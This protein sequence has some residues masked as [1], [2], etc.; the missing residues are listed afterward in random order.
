[1]TLD[2][3]RALIARWCNS[4]VDE[5]GQIAAIKSL[6]DFLEDIL[7]NQYEP[8]TSG[9]HGQFGLRLARW[10]GS[11]GTE[12][13]QRALYLLLGHLTFFGRDQMMAGYRTAYSRHVLSWLSEVEHVQFFCPSAE[14]MLRTAVEKTAF[15]E[16]TDS[17]G[18]GNFFRWN[19]LA[20]R[21]DGY[22]WAQHTEKDWK[23]EE[24]EAAV[25][26]RERAGE[27]STKKHLVLLEDFVGTGNQMADAVELACSLS[28]QYNVLL[29]PIVICPEGAR[30]ARQ[31]ER[32][33]QQFTFDPVL[34]LPESAFI[35]REHLPGEDADYRLIRQALEALHPQ[36]CGLS[37][38][39][40]EGMSPYGYEDTGAI[41]CKYD[42]CPDNTVPAI[43]H[44]PATGWDP[45]FFR[46]SRE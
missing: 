35:T 42:N 1:M 26:G 24:F 30:R 41:F 18:L 9:G 23:P 34:E 17:F 25:M 22:T 11:A 4:E 46:T 15:T 6:V 12:E 13:Y 14:Q 32:E 16:I 37:A 31:L 27:A 40:A 2:D 28:N 3:F 29:C 20:G 33:H 7:F 45:L 10:I 21:S 5:T 44:R 39:G 19:N 36:V 43:H 8:T 38:P